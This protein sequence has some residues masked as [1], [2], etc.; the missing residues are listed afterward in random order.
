LPQFPAAHLQKMNDLGKPMAVI[1][2]GFEKG[3][4][5]FLGIRHPSNVFIIF[6][7]F[8]LY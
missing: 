8:N 7:S 5:C 1:P 4:P 2:L 3:C 6:N